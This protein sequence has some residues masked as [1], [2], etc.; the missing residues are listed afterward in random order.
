[1]LCP[2]VV[3]LLK[4]VVCYGSSRS[5]HFLLWL[6][7]EE[8]FSTILYQGFCVQTCVPWSQVLVNEE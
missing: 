6:T 3:S 2:S 4:L 5:T 1:M 8:T 7:T